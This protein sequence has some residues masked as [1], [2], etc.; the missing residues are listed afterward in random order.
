M[1]GNAGCPAPA[2][3]RPGLLATDRAGGGPLA[4]Q[5]ALG[6]QVGLDR[7]ADFH[8]IADEQADPGQSGNIGVQLGA[9][10]LALVQRHAALG[11]DD[12]HGRTGAV[13]GAHLGGREVDLGIQPAGVRRRGGGGHVQHQRLHAQ[14]NGR[15]AR[16]QQVA[17]AA[18][19]ASLATPPSVEFQPLCPAWKPPRG[20][21]RRSPG[22][23]WRP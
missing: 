17:I 21:R 20:R 9:Q 4:G 23:P 3:R 14:R 11:V 15:V 2:G 8:R 18:R 22:G 1:P 19:N 13:D 6:F 5:G 7:A 10:G 16:N 12:Q